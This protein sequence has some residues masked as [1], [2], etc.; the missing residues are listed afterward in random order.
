MAVLQKI[1]NG[2]S[3]PVL[4]VFCVLV[5]LGLGAMDFDFN[6]M[7]NKTKDNV[8]SIYDEDIKQKEF[9]ETL[10]FVKKT[11]QSQNL[12]EGQKISFAWDK[13]IKDK[14]INF[15]AKNIGLN[16]CGKELYELETGSIDPNNVSPY[17][18]SFFINPDTKQFDKDLVDSWLENFD[19][20]DNDRRSIFLNL[21]NEAIQIRYEQKYQALID[22]GMYITTDEA[23]RILEE[24]SQNANVSYVSIPYSTIDDIEV[25]EEE[26]NE[27]YIKNIE[28][29][30]NDNET[31]NIEY[32]TFTVIPSSQ[33]DLNVR[34][35]LTKLS[36]KFNDSDNDELFASRY[37]SELIES[38]P[39]LKKEQVT[40]PKFSELIEMDLGSV[41]GPYKLTNGRYRLS[42]FSELAKRPDSVEARHILLNSENYSIDS[43]KIILKDLKNQVKSGIDFGE[44]AMKYSDDNGSK[45]KGGELGWFKEGQMVPQFEEACFSS[46]KGDLKIVPTQYGLHLIQV[47]KVSK[48][49]NKYKIVHLDLDVLP[50]EETKDFYYNQAKDLISGLQNKPNDTSFSSYAQ[51][52]NQLIREDVNVDKMKYNVSALENSRDIVKWVFDAK[53]GDFSNTIYTC[54]DNYVVASL[55]GINFEG[56]LDLELVR[57]QIIQK[58]QIEKKY[59]FIQKKIAEGSS[60]DN[61]SK[62]FSAEIKTIEGVNFNNNN[63]NEIGNSPNFVGV[64]NSID[65]NTVSP[66]IKGVNAAYVLL[67]NNK[68]ES[69]ENNANSTQ[70]L[71]IQNS[72]F[73]GIFYNSAMKVLKENAD[74]VD[75]RIN[76]Y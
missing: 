3:L 7:F 9:S 45:I 5:L 41:L 39:Y 17:F 61:I 52:Q 27:Y 26:I 11:Q 72:K 56:D 10:S 40:D 19:N 36:L 67:V 29:F 58:I 54:G 65:I 14:I 35:K 50:S 55:S 31:R 51:S 33:D 42:K 28:D 2:F 57:E 1:R 13:L 30:Q 49:I 16:V 44:L 68:S 6:S 69:S 47:T 15:S 74:I 59:E 48:L 37:T 18:S 38:F 23:S 12:Q 8:G 32:V 76:F 43:A 25:T 60:L 4:L 20:L 34:E 73:T 22:K 75:E 24:K 21:E 63:V 66:I 62:T 46:K 71:E 70:R 64:V 53:V